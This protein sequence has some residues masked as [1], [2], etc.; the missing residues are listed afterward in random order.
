MASN[1]LSLDLL[2]TFTVFVKEGTVDQAAQKLSMTQAA[3]SIQLKRLEQ[4]LGQPL[5]GWS[6]RKKVLTD[7]GKDLSVQLS[8]PLLQLESLLEK[9]SL[10]RIQGTRPSL[11]VTGSP[12]LSLSVSEKISDSFNL[13]FIAQPVSDEKAIQLLD[14]YDVVLSFKK[15]QTQS[16]LLSREAFQI[17]FVPVGLENRN[18]NASLVLHNELRALLPK[19]LQIESLN[20]FKGVDWLQVIQA[21][22]KLSAWTYLPESSIADSGLEILKNKPQFKVP[23][24]ASAKTLEALKF[25]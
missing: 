8:P 15:I 17:N 4:E 24:F 3:V 20:S 22:K 21:T 6:G 25:F 13:E 9:V 11:K 10:S 19:S 18:K 7:F 16:L 23:V 5:F 1:K 12:L 14:F 2:R